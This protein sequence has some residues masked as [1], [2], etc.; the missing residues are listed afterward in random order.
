MICSDSLSAITALENAFITGP[1]SIIPTSIN[2]F[3]VAIQN[4]IK[5]IW[6]NDRY[7]GLLKTSRQKI[8]KWS[9][10][11]YFNSKKT[12]NVLSR[13]YYIGH[14]RKTLSYL[15]IGGDRLVYFQCNGRF[16]V[17]HMFAYPHNLYHREDLFFEKKIF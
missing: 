4:K 2:D 1:K 14:T 12:S 10:L 11:K 3:K 9:Y 5:E 6:Q 17:N 13:S 15:L 7:D 16:T 8:D